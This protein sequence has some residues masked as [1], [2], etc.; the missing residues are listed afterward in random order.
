[1]S[2]KPKP[3]MVPATESGLK[4]LAGMLS[5]FLPRVTMTGAT[6]TSLD[7]LRIREDSDDTDSVVGDWVAFPV[8]VGQSAVVLRQGTRRVLYPLNP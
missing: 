3:L 2:S 4:G 5:R 8:R 1:M 7:P 6:V